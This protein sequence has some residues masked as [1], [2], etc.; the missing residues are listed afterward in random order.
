VLDLG[1]FKL[2]PVRAGLDLSMRVLL[3]F[4]TL[5]ALVT[6]AAGATGCVPTTSTPF[7]EASGFYVAGNPITLIFCDVTCLI[8]VWIYEESN[9]ITGLQRQDE[10]HDDTCNGAIAGDT[11]RM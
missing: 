1:Q 7:A 2:S 8:D 6:G 9:D 5:L 3:L 4:I 10:I 11:I